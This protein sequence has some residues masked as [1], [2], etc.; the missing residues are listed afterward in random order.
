MPAPVNHR[1]MVESVSPPW[2][3]GENSA[4]YYGAT[5]GLTGDLI[6]ESLRRILL[7]PWLLESESPDDVLSLIGAELRL[8]RYP[9]ETA[10][11][12]RAR[13]L[14]WKAIYDAAGTLT[15]INAQITPAHLTGTVLF[16]PGHPGPNFEPSY[17]SQSWILT[18]LLDAP[19]LELMTSIARKLK[20]VYWTFRGFVANDAIAMTV[21][22]LIPVGD[23]VA[24]GVAPLG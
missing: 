16:Q 20:S 15:G 21:P 24:E 8:P 4:G 5:L 22:D 2:A 17:W 9:N 7:M 13:L 6:A 14:V 10:A 12:Y 11:A 23:T 18:S 3:V 1:A 19:S